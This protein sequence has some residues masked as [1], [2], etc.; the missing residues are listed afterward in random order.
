MES[1][2]LR[3]CFGSNLFG[4]ADFF[5]EGGSSPLDLGNQRRLLK[6]AVMDLSRPVSF[7]HMGDSIEFRGIDEK[8]R[9]EGRRFGDQTKSQAR[10]PAAIGHGLTHVDNLDP[11]DRT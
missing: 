2:P 7:Y 10:W 6:L 8:A 11:A 5:E 1:V 9:I 3:D 4:N